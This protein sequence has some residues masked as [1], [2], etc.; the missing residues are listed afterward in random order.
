MW[1]VIFVWL[2]WRIFKYAWFDHKP[3]IPKMERK[4]VQA[5]NKDHATDLSL[6]FWILKTADSSERRGHDKRH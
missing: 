4:R 1:V 5:P 2:C 3:G 6:M